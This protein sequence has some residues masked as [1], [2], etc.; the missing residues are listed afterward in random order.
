MTYPTLSKDLLEQRLQPPSGHIRMVLDTDTY[1]EIDDQFAVVYALRS[2]EKLSVEALYAA[3][4]TNNRS[5]GPGDGMEKSYDEIVRLLDRL[6]VSPR[7][8][9]YRGSTDL[10]GQPTGAQPGGVGP[11][12]AGDGCARRRPA[13]CGCDRGDHQRCVSVVDRT[14]DHPQDRGGLA[15]WQPA[16][17]CR[18]PSNST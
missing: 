15:G 13:V 16:R 18:T 14:G 2:P 17:C 1:N 3:P 8:F 6:H 7:G 9:V 12:S 4:F 10:S 11:G 5:T